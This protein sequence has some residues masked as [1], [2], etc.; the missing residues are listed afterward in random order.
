[1]NLNLNL[2]MKTSMKYSIPASFCIMIVFFLSNYNCSAQ[3]RTAD[4]DKLVLVYK[5]NK[6]FYTEKKTGKK[7]T[8]KAVRYSES[9]KVLLSIDF[10][11]GRESGFYKEFTETGLLIK[12]CKVKDALLYDCRE[13]IKITH[14][15]RGN[16]NRDTDS[17]RV[18]ISNI[19]YD[20]LFYHYT[21]SIFNENYQWPIFVNK[22]WIKCNDTDTSGLS[23]FDVTQIFKYTYIPGGGRDEIKISIPLKCGCFDFIYLPNDKDNDAEK[24]H[25]WAQQP[26]HSLNFG[27]L[28]VRYSGKI[29]KVYSP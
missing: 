15:P 19:Q 22:Q 9:G 14:S 2:M 18:E 7:F 28:V 5:N 10:K 1:V 6:R 13:Y 11:K 25:R 26:N 12:S 29:I 20:S 3:S 27:G 17:V 8:G 21:F 24:E 4:F 23:S 16:N